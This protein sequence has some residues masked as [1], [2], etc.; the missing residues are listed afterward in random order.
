ML[1]LQGTKLKAIGLYN[2]VRFSSNDI[3]LDC[4][5]LEALIFWCRSSNIF[6]FSAEPISVLDVC[7]ITGIKFNGL[8]PAEDIEI[9]IVNSSFSSFIQ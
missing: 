8:T 4:N 1:K 2:V 5:I 7:A 9:I 3:E 6:L